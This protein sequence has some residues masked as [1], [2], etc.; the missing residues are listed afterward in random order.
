MPCMPMMPSCSGTR[1]A[2]PMP[3]LD[4]PFGL[5]LTAEQFEK[6]GCVEGLRIELW[7]GN[8]DVSASAQVA[9]HGLVKHRIA[10][11]FEAD[12]QT[13]STGIGVA[14]SDRTVREPDVTRF[15]RGASPSLQQSQFPVAD[16]DLVVEVV[17]PES[18]KRDRVIK[19]DEYAAAGVPE[20]LPVEEDP[21]DEADAVINIYRLAESGAYALVRSVDLSVLQKEN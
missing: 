21:E 10:D 6:L 19:P 17:T 20:F 7:D 9:W 8:L 11:L 14:L 13:V 1:E 3:T 5:P 2:D 4:L 15:R 16:V 18:D 12:G